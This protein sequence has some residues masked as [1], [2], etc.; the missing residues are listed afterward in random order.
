MFCSPSELH[1]GG[2]QPPAA[3]GAGRAAAVRAAGARRVPAAAALR[4][5]DHLQDA[6][7]H[8]PSASLRARFTPFCVKNC[9]REMACNCAKALLLTRNVGMEKLLR[10]VIPQKGKTL[11]GSGGPFPWIWFF[12]THTVSLRETLWLILQCCVVS[13]AERFSLRKKQNCELCC[14]VRKSTR[15]LETSTQH[16]R[17]CGGLLALSVYHETS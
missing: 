17:Q 8:A 10:W 14:S 9:T 4:R 12:L 3:D 11:L 7:A 13:S 2:V 1:V 6:G 5:R 15:N 16:G